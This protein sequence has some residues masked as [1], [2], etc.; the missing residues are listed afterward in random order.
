MT[1]NDRLPVGTVIADYKRQIADLADQLADARK[2]NMR[3]KK[4]AEDT[5]EWTQDDPDDEDCR[6]WNGD[7]GIMWQFEDGTPKE[8]DMNFC[9]K[10]GKQLV[11]IKT[12]ESEEQS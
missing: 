7:C 8:N 11:E 9:P 1:V 10:C 3:L 2:E 4:S 12:P 5:C 6:I